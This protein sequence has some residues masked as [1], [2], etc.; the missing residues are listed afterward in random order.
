[1][2]PEERQF[3]VLDAKRGK[4]PK[5]DPIHFYKKMGFRILAEREKGTI[6]MYLD[7]WLEDSG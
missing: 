7:V 4:D 5:F 6:P 1:M 3:L 2:V